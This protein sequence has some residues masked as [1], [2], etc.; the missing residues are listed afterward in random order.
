MQKFVLDMGILSCIRHLY[1]KLRYS[2]MYDDYVNE[3]QHILLSKYCTKGV[4]C[5]RHS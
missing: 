2:E 5:Q 1:S 4:N 3:V